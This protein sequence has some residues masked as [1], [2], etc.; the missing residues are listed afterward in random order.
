MAVG[1]CPSLALMLSLATIPLLMGVVS[2]HY[3]EQILE[4]LGQ[5]SETLL[6]QER[7]PALPFPSFP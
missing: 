4:F 2:N 6:K 7:L 3:L 1:A 5:K